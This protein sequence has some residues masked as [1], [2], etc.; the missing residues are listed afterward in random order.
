VS[1]AIAV[2]ALAGQTLAALP[3][4]L[5]TGLLVAAG[6]FAVVTNWNGRLDVAVRD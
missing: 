2:H 5:R 6:A 4:R 3:A 1:A